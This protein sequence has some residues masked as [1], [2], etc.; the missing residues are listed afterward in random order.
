MGIGHGRH[1]EM[2]AR[3]PSPKDP[4]C[5]RVTSLPHTVTRPLVHARHSY[6]SASNG[7]SLA[8][9]RAGQIAAKIPTTT[10]VTAKATN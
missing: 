7:F 6:C 10:E 4:S 1:R 9:L 2:W 5:G 3:G 8:A